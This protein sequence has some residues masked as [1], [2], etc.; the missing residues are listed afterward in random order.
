MT[1]RDS[2]APA[3]GCTVFDRDPTSYGAGFNA[4]GGGVFA[5]LFAETGCAFLVPRPQASPRAYLAHPPPRSISI[6]RWPRAQVPT[7]VKRGWPKWQLWG[8]PVAAWDGATCDTRQFFKNQKLTFVR[9]PF[10]PVSG[11]CKA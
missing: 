11:L 4:A 9:L 1:S 3:A 7:D 8:T 5:V 10:L 6:W 2:R